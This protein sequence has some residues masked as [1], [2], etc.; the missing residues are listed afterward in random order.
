M[1]SCFG[2]RSVPLN[3]MCSS[4]VREPA[5]IVVLEDEPALTASHSSRGSRACVLART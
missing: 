3:A 5:L 1:I 2:N 4:E